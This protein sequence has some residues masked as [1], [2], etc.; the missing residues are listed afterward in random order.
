MRK[1]IPNATCA[2]CGRPFY[3]GQ[4][5][6][7]SRAICTLSNERLGRPMEVLPT[8]SVECFYSMGYNQEQPQ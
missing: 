6:A 1:E 3:E 2:R 8:C 4:M 5:T 7:I